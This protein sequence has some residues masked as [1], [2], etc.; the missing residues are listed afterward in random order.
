MSYT[1]VA[2]S[3]GNRVAGKCEAFI[4]RVARSFSTIANERFRVRYS[5]PLIP[6]RAF[7]AMLRIMGTS[8]NKRVRTQWTRVA[9][10][11]TA[12][13]SGVLAERARQTALGAICICVL[14]RKAMLAFSGA[15]RVGKPPR[16]ARKALDRRGTAGILTFVAAV[17][18]QKTSRSRKFARRTKLALVRA[19][20][21]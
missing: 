11:R 20:V 8:V 5:Q 4:S 1:F 6:S 13:L 2:L 10:H 21:V 18:C 14:P 15:R 9:R 17:T 16:G 19:V 7:F 12:R 3:L